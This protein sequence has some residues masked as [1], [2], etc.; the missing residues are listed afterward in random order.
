MI[1]VLI[2]LY[3]VEQYIARCLDSVL[4]QTYQNFEIVV[5]NDGSPDNSIHVVKIYAERDKRIRII[6]NGENMGLAWTRMVGYT[7]ARGSYIVFL[8][9]DDFLPKDALKNLRS[10]IE[11]TKADI[12]IG[13][14]QKVDSKG[15]YGKKSNNK[16]LYGNGKRT[17]FKSLLKNEISQSLCGKMY[18][19]KLFKDHK[20]VTY[21]NFVNAEDG[22]LL[23]QIIENTNN[24]RV[25]DNIVYHYYQNQTSSTNSNL[26]ENGVKS[27]VTHWNALNTVFRNDKELNYLCFKRNARSYIAMMRHYNLIQNYLEIDELKGKVTFSK[28]TQSDSPWMAIKKYVY[29]YFLRGRM[30][31]YRYYQAIKGSL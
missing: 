3:N 25:I 10:A 19:I 31:L 22:F 16:L 11:T 2:P 17:V 13:N 27:I 4:S 24:I 23:Y 28:L 6:E 21:K 9:S 5:V 14:F 15:V 1:S 29:L 20:Y 8:D 30:R 12:I 7:N 18:N 26:T